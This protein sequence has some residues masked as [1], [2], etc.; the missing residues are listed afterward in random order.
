MIETQ[1]KIDDLPS[2][3]RYP[4]GNGYGEEVL[5][6][7]Y[8]MPAG[9]SL[10]VNGEMPQRGHALPIGKG[11]VVRPF[12]KQGK[13]GQV[14]VSLL[15]LG[16]RLVDSVRAARAVEAQMGEEVVV[17]VADARFMKP[18]DE[19]LIRSLAKESQVLVTVEE[20]SQGGFGAA[21]SLFLSEQGLLDTGSL[22]L[23][24]MVIP[25]KWIG[26]FLCSSSYSFSLTPSIYLSLYLYLYP[27]TVQRRVRRRINTT[28]RS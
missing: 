19:E 3:T 20:G 1:H 11:R 18:L 25:D 12:P 27:T 9:T 28:W 15:S 5:N 21:V 2:V 7:I 23:R 13:E 14:R 4:R 8:G 22:M 10:Y 17:Q 6:D 24:T 16:T 26:S